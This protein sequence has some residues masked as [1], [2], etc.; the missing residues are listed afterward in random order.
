[1]SRASN[2]VSLAEHRTPKLTQPRPYGIEGWAE[3]HGMDEW[4]DNLESLLICIGQRRMTTD[5]L[6]RYARLLHGAER[7]ALRRRR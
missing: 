5:Q 4:L 7:D 1:M 2:L 3:I 6:E